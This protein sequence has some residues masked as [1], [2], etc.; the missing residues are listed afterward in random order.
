M[1][2]F[3]IKLFV[4]N[5]Y[6][7][8]F[9]IKIIFARSVT[10]IIPFMAIGMYSAKKEYN[11]LALISAIT[12]I[13]AFFIPS[14]YFNKKPAKWNELNDIQKW[15]YLKQSTPKNIDYKQIENI[16][17][18]VN[19]YSKKTFHNIIPILI[20]LVPAGIIVIVIFNLLKF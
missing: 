7:V 6:T 3:L 1:R 18:K 14:V 10:V 16:N 20:S 2:K 11:T 17:K 8:A 19:S 4:L 12:V 13:I 15:F 5:Y 9:K